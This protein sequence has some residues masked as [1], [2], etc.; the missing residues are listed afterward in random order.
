MSKRPSFTGFLKNKFIWSVPKAC[1][2]RK[3]DCLI[4]NEC[5]YGL[6]Q[7]ARQYDEKAFEIF[8]KY[9]ILSHSFKKKR[10][11]RH[12]FIAFYVD[13]NNMVDAI[14][15]ELILKILDEL[16]GYLS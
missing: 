12:M 13:D 14:E 3:D 7:G 1:P 2:K 10:M 4:L 16:Q 9:E 15:D 11:K 5:I 8:M 6:V